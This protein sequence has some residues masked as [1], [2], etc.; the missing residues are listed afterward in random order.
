MTNA[1]RRFVFVYPTVLACNVLLHHCTDG[2]DVHVLSNPAKEE[3]EKKNEKIATCTY[4]WNSPEHSFQ[5]FL[6]YSWDQ[7]Q[8]VYFFFQLFLRIFF[9]F[10]H[11]KNNRQVLS[12]LNGQNWNSSESQ[13][14]IL[15][16]IL[17]ML[18]I[19]YIIYHI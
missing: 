9:F 13:I 7:C 8:N 14:S 1:I 2:L 11:K 16:Y 3:A 10:L 12:D 17:Y 19:L 6:K 5:T 18:Y 4:V 15:Y